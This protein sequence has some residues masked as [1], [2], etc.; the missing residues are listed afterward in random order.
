M[1]DRLPM[2]LF[3]LFW[4]VTCLDPPYPGELVLQHIPTAIAL[5]ALGWGHRR[6]EL[7]RSSVRLVLLFMALHALGAR[8]LYSYVP[9]DDWS[10]VLCGRPISS[11][12]GFTRNH[13]DRLVHF[14]YG[15]LLYLPLGEVISR[16]LKPRPA[17]SGVLAVQGIL[18]TSAA[19][20]IIEW[21]VALTFAPEWSEH[22][23]GQQG[24]IWDAQKDMALAAAGALVALLCDQCRR[25]RL[26]ISL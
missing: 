9:Y 26:L 23:N 13:Y 14:A 8:Y 17:W 25:I 7:S 21:C 1:A 22:Y 24:D 4:A 2:L 10:M 15:L 6:L 20:E 12:F 3:V 11:R 5:V 18:A 16:T 19:Y